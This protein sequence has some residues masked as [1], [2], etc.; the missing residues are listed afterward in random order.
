MIEG[1]R[2]L[3]SSFCAP[4]ISAGDMLSITALFSRSIVSFSLVAGVFGPEDGGFFS[5]APFGVDGSSGCDCLFF[6]KAETR[7]LWTGKPVPEVVDVAFGVGKLGG[8]GVPTSRSWISRT[9]KVDSMF[10]VLLLK[11]V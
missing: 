5:D 7:F 9:C 8:L 3:N 11:S 6:L 1:P 2:A 10:A 4:A